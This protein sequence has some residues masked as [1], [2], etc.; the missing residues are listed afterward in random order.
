MKV[1]INV[2]QRD[3]ERGGLWDV[4]RCP[5]ARAFRRHYKEATVGCWDVSL[6]KLGGY[7]LP[8]SAKQFRLRFDD[9]KKVRPF[10]FDME[11]P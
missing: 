2:T 4:E 3:I 11:V 1:R 6:G 9:G 5:L 10:S 8:D 7:A